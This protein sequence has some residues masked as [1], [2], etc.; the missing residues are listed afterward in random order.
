M[1][2]RLPR[3]WRLGLVALA[4]ALLL[5]VAPTST[6]L[7]GGFI[8]PGPSFVLTLL[9]ND[10]GESKLLDAGTGLEDFGGV[11]RFA[12]LVEHL[13]STPFAGPAGVR[14]G[15]LTLSSGDNFLARVEFSAS[16]ARSDGR[17][18]DAIALDAIGYDAIAL[19]NHDFDF[20]PEVLAR[21]IAD[22]ASGT[23]FL[24][25]NLDF[26]NE[27]A[28]QALA[29]AGRIAPSTVVT[30]GVERIGIVGATTS[31]LPYVSSPRNVGVNL[32][33]AGAVQ[34]QVDALLAQGVNK[35]IISSHLQ[36]I[37]EDLALAERLTGV[38]IVIAGG[39]DE[40]L[41][42]AGDLLVPGDEDAVCGE[43]PLKAIDADGREVLVVTVPGRYRYVGRLIVGFD[44]AGEIVFVDADSGPVRV[45]GGAQPDAVAEHAFVKANVTDP[46]AAHVADLRVR[47]VGA[48]TVALEGTWSQI[49]T[50]ETNLG[51]LIA[52]ALLWQAT[53]LAAAYGTVVPDVGIQNGGGIRNNSLIPAGDITEADVF[54]MVP[55][56]SFVTVV[57]DVSA[58]QFKEI[59]E[60]AVSQIESGS[61][62]FA[63]IAGFRF[64]YDPHGTAQE[65]DE[66][67]EV[68]TA[69]AR[70][71]EV[72]LDDGRVIVRNGEVVANA[73]SVSIATID[74]LARG[75]DQYPY[76]DVEFVP[77]GVSY[78]Q[79]V[80]DY[81]GEALGGEITEAAYPDGANA[82][83]RPG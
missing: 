75:G 57:P 13:R 25:A 51:N 37:V 73:P 54:A 50:R 36:S 72:V 17:F 45:A 63:Q 44:D 35:I 60:N 27:P 18:Y 55:F 9:H 62:R 47:V 49:R 38:D 67:G 12:T 4:A 30:V 16:L 8:P 6:V 31:Q 2:T 79:A 41:A 19:G 32:D 70:I 59:L 28:L 39:G 81:V 40:L 7:G 61:G 77:L 29:D 24:S 76:G 1:H 15:F 56:P 34:A 65:L 3:R 66:N 33:V 82:R 42:G 26:T 64:K 43:Y 71:R 52:D 80:R 53:R 78:Q 23:P 20:G 5:L 68:I 58:T 10:D 48:S 46:V 69:G 14:T 83:I 21:F 22:F 11:A 74:F